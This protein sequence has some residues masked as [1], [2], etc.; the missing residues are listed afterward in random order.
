MRKTNSKD[1]QNLG[2]NHLNDEEIALCAQYLIY[3]SCSG[4]IPDHIQIHL[5]VCHKCQTTVFDLYHLICDEPMLKNALN[6][7]EKHILN[8]Q[9]TQHKS[10]RNKRFL[11]FNRW[12]ASMAIA[13]SVF[14]LV[15]ISVLVFNKSVT[16]AE[17]LFAQYYTPYHDVVT[18]KSSIDNR[19]LLNGLFYYNTGE[20]KKAINHFTNGLKLSP[21]DHDM[22]FY[23]AGSYLAIG[24]YTKSIEI[25][26]L[27][28]KNSLTYYSPA[29][30]YLALSYLAGNKTCEARSLLILI[31][32][33][34]GFYA[35]KAGEILHKLPPT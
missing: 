20:Y 1:R 17:Q 33:E 12:Y 4:S 15:L 16:D 2:M 18:S 32:D 28:H 25:Y 26:E 24:D 27:L 10:A 5:N 31:R 23:L 34:G 14:V 6:K 29:L 11:Q 21:D 3:G 22:L 7:G 8:L 9:D 30:W 13:A 35:S 19:Y